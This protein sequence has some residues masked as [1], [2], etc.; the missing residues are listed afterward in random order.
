MLKMLRKSNG[1]ITAWAGEKAK[2]L[3]DMMKEMP[4][5]IMK[6]NKQI[7][8]VKMPEHMKHRQAGWA[9]LMFKNCFSSKRVTTPLERKPSWRN[10]R[11]TRVL[12][13]MKDAS[14]RI[15]I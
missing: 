7:M 11:S 15:P 1:R 13:C 2:S 4:E 12:H 14:Q 6:M 8:K 9:T 10:W 3:P 5:T